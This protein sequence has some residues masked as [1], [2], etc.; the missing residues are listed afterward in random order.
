MTTPVVR[1]V[2]RDL[3]LAALSKQGIPL[4]AQQL[5]TALA[6]YWDGNIMQVH[7]VLRELEASGLAM[8]QNGR[9]VL[10]GG[11]RTPDLWRRTST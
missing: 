4:T 3:T 11:G 5:T 10:P 9:G 8:R 2:L 1:L 6:P 7:R